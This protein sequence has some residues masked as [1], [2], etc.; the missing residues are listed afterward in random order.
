MKS[1]TPLVVAL[2]VMASLA[3]AEV[4]TADQVLSQAK[5]K[6]AADHKAI[7]VHFGASGAAGANAWMRSWSGPTSN[8]SSRVFHPGK[9]R[10]AGKRQEQS[11]GESGSRR[12]AQ[13]AWRAFRSAVFAFLDAQAP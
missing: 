11:P 6:A 2:C 1:I 10:G 8:P 12:G 7:F 9:A 5:A 4:P 13:T 3:R